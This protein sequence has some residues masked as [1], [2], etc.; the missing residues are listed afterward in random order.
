[1]KYGS[2]KLYFR[3]PKRSCT[4]HIKRGLNNAFPR[5][6]TVVPSGVRTRVRRIRLEQPRYPKLHYSL[7]MSRLVMHSHGAIPVSVEI[8]PDSPRGQ[9]Q[10]H[11]VP[12]NPNSG[13]RPP[14]AASRWPKPLSLAC[15]HWETPYPRP[16]QTLPRGSHISRGLCKVPHRLAP[17]RRK[18]T[19]MLHAGALVGTHAPGRTE[20]EWPVCTCR[21]DRSR[22]YGVSAGLAVRIV[23]RSWP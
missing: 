22:R 2:T 11:P 15:C 21:S 16:G 5:V 9:F 18:Y 7:V 20:R 4:A 3:C 1:M 19:K 8:P 6:N 12:V 10:A 23:C 14:V 13:C 17:A